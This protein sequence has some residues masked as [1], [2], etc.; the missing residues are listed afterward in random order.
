M[1]ALLR[2]IIL[3]LPMLLLCASVLPSDAH[4]QAAI[5]PYQCADDQSAAMSIPFV[6][7]AFTARLVLCIQGTIFDALTLMLTAISNYMQPITAIIMVF[8]IIV[9]GVRLISGEKNLKPKAAGF[10]IRMA[11]VVMFSFE[12]GGLTGDIFSIFDELSMLGSTE[13]FVVNYPGYP[14]I[15]RSTPWDLLDHFMGVFL[16]FSLGANLMQGFLG[17]IT[18]VMYNS[19]AGILMFITGLMAILNIFFF[20]LRV[21]FTYLTSYIII[22]F[23]IILSPFIIPLALFYWTER[24]F[25]KWLHVLISAML[26]P[27]ILFAFLAMFLNLFGQLIG[28]VFCPLGFILTDLLRVNPRPAYCYDLSTS[29]PTAIGVVVNAANPIDFRAFFRLNQP[30][31]SWLMPGDPASENE[32]ANITNAES[33]GV[34]SVQ[35]NIN[36][37]ARRAM[38]AGSAGV[39]GVDFGPNTIQ[40]IQAMVLAFIK[41][42]IFG[43]IMTAMVKKI[44][45]IS[46]DIAGTG[47]ITSIAPTKLETG[48]KRVMGDFKDKFAAVGM[49]NKEELMNLAR[50]EIKPY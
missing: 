5:S 13:A 42:W 39:P 25:T 47:L 24:Y 22:A 49:K 38:D 40:T 41:L 3:I 31:F 21:L 2:Q 26:T 12:L 19:T 29:P 17:L 32:L 48:A 43:T 37:M 20:A 10:L 44:P 27:M 30:L 9:F 14:T 35:S 46:N 8:A 7:T 6:T 16:G 4:A 18:G 11:L 33:V 36:P 34:P 28:E 50:R 15:L 23:L 1:I 45:E